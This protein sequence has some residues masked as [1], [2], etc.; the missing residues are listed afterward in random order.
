[1]LLFEPT[2]NLDINFIADYTSRE[3]NCCVGVTTERGPTANLADALAGGPGRGIIPVADPDRRLGYANRST[4][5]D[6]KDKGIS[7]EVNWNTPWLNGATLTSI[8]A[9]RDWQSINAIDFDFSGADV[10]Y[11]N[12]DIDESSTSFES[13]SQE[14]RFTGSTDRLDW[15]VG[16]FYSDEYLLRNDQ[17]VFGEDYEAYI[18]A[19]TLS[20]IAGIV[21]QGVA[22]GRYPPGSVVNQANPFAFVSEVTGL[23]Q[24]TNFVGVGAQDR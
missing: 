19:A 21:A 15:M 4:E 2:D 3:E 8:T 17:Y 13:F 16:A 18:S 1:Q 9:F 22:A 5:Q 6:I 24:G 23:A 11:R 12:A 20:R 10:L 7:A 14:F